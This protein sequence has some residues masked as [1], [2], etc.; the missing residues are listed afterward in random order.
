MGIWC[1]AHVLATPFSRTW[2]ENSDSSTSTPTIFVTLTA[3]SIVAADASD[4]PMPPI[5]RAFTYASRF[6]SVCSMGTLLSTRAY[7]KISIL[8]LPSKISRQFS[9]ERLT[10][11]GEPSGC[12]LESRPPYIRVNTSVYFRYVPKKHRQK[13]FKRAQ[14]LVD[15]IKSMWFFHTLILKTTCDAFSGYLVKYLSMT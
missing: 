10:P 11:S 6:F 12:R 7:S 13:P 1:F 2:V 8:F 14:H 5:L 9:T 4:R 3:F 15:K